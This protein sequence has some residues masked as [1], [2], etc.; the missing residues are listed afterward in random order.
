[1]SLSILSIGTAVPD[2]VV[3]AAQAEAVARALCNSPNGAA[4]LPKIYAGT[5]ITTRH[6][7]ITR[8]VLDDVIAGSKHSG[9]AFLPTGDVDDAGPTT[10]RRMVH[11]AEHATPLALK[12]AR[13]A[14]ERST[15][16]SRDITHLVTISCTGFQAPGVDVA[17]IK[18]LDLALTTERTHV[19]FMGCHAALN[20]LRV[21]RG[22]ADADAASRILVCAVEVCSVHYHYGFDAQRAVANSLFADGAAALIG[23]P[24]SEGPDDAWRLAAS[25]ACL[26]PDSEAAMSWSIGD[27]GFVMTL[28][29]QIPALI[30]RS[31]APFMIGWLARHGLALADVATWAV[32]PGG[33][34]IVTAVE[35]ALG[36]DTSATAASRAILDEYG[37][38]S[39]PTI[40]FVIDRLR[41]GNAPRPCV[42]IG[43]GP[44]LNAE[45]ALFL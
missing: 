20:G 19:G 7:S 34:R 42:A 10:A 30:G 33:P 43:F 25:G 27:H 29:R 15:L 16:A 45:V 18:G 23:V 39:S 41:R 24:D 17:L 1:M 9:S 2:T 44:G 8:A 31:L 22:F 28:S 12:A 35:E 21:A 6:L 3:T 11:Y 37:N 36:L 38:M 32:H 4:W 14:L 26:F 13:Q 5:G 40:L